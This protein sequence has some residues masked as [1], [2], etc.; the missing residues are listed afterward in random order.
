MRIAQITVLAGCV[1]VLAACGD[2]RYG[3]EKLYWKAEQR[4]AKI[5]ARKGP[6]NLTAD[7]YARIIEGYR[8]VTSTYPYQYKTVQAH[9]DIARVYLAQ[10]KFEPA[11]EELETVIH[12][13]SA[14]PKIASRAQFAIAKLYEARREYE[15]ALEE[16]DKILDLYPVTPIGLETP[17]YLI[18]FHERVRD[19]QEEA[20]RAYQRALR[21]Y[22]SLAGEYGEETPVGV[23]VKDYLARTYLLKEQWQDAAGVWEEVMNQKEVPLLAGKA[24]LARASLFADQLKEPSR[25]IEL[26]KSFEQKFP[27]SRMLPMALFQLGRVYLKEGNLPEAKETFEKIITQFPRNT[28]LNILSRVA[29]AEAYKKE[30]DLEAVR[31]EYTT[32]ESAYPESP[33]VFAVPYLLYTYYR[34]AG[35]DTKA[36]MLLELAITEYE[37]KLERIVDQRKKDALAQWLILSYRE[38]GQ[39]QKAIDVLDQLAEDFPGDPRYPLAAAALYKNQ[40]KDPA[41]ALKMYEEV[42]NAYPLNEM[43]TDSLQKQIESL[44]G[45]L[46]V[47][48]Q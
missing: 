39:W 36:A 7:D 38:K 34:D 41:G 30:G 16:Y 8:R 12:N 1:A 5:I 33:K 48:D 32:L 26:Y 43:V 22:R 13:F 15:T 29:I 45:V 21:H 10:D 37:K 20:A 35:R 19:D 42:Q 28:E 17:I 23:A 47:G 40:M 14:A 4:A 25:A 27:R 24:Q 46:K 11:L 18:R 31:R 9:F 6:G 2:A 3:S 44:Q